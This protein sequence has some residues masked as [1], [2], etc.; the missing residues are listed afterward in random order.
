[1][2]TTGPTGAT[3]PGGVVSGTGLIRPDF[4]EL[5]DFPFL[6]QQAE[7]VLGGGATNFMFLV[8]AADRLLDPASGEIAGPESRVGRPVGPIDLLLASQNPGKLGGD[9]PARRG[10]AVPGRGTEGPGDHRG[11]RRDRAELRGERDPEGALL[12]R[13]D[14]GC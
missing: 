2:A 3:S 5:K 8:L 14:P 9:A 4:P 13:G 10:D 1:M 12:R 6:W 7:Y 11:A